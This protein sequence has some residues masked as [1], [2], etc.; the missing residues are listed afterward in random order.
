MNA[1]VLFFEELKKHIKPVKGQTDVNI[2]KLKR[3]SD[4]L[5]LLLPE[6]AF[7]LP[8][9]N[10]ARL[11]AIINEAGYTS[12]CLDLNIEVYN[13]SRN[14]EK[15][16]IVP[17]DPFNPHNLTKW[18]IDEYPKYLK[19]PVSKVLEKYIDKIV[20]LNPKVLGFTLYYCNEGPVDWFAS[21]LRKRLPNTIFICGGPNLHF[22]QHDIEK[23]KIFSLNNK[24]VFQ[25]GIVGE[26]ELI[27]LDILEEIDNGKMNH[28]GMKFLT[29]PLNQRININN[30][31][32]PNYSDMDFSKYDMPNGILTEFSRGCIAKCTFCSETHFWKYRQRNPLSALDEIEH[33]YKTKGTNVVWF[34]DSLINGNLK[35]LKEF[36]EGVIER[37]LKIKWA[38]FARCDERMDLEYLK[39]LNK[40]GCFIL[41]IGAESASNNVLSDMSKR[42]TRE[43]M[44]QNF[45]D[46]NKV[47][48]GVI[49]TWINGFPT[50]KEIDHKS[51]L[52]FLCRNREHIIGAASAA[53]FTIY[54]ENIVGQNP[55]RF[56]VANFTYDM[57]W[58]RDDFS[59]GK[60]HMLCRVKNYEILLQ[61][62]NDFSTIKLHPRP[63][64]KKLYNI[65]YDEPTLFNEIEYN[66]TNSKVLNTNL[67]IFGDSLIKQPFILFEILWKIRGGYEMNLKFDEK[68]DDL[69][70][71]L[72]VAS[73]YNAEYNF[74]INKKGD[75]SCTIVAKYTQPKDRP[76]KVMDFS[77]QKSS[78]IERARVFAKPT[79]GDGSRTK[80]ELI[81]L[82]KEEAYLNKTKDFSFDFKWE[83][84]GTWDTSKK[85]LF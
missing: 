69:E 83:G 54:A 72:P 25:Y 62:I 13:Q 52:T 48:I 81:E 45:S 21:E 76:F 26:A 29:Q 56:G 3:N 12:S 85:S 33:L 9:Y 46:F 8:P 17:F 73:P 71:G 65:K 34:L 58:I 15:D 5:F 35:S 79:W 30:F 7:D 61:E 22:R 18:E 23:G 42:M 20:E 53:G 84:S 37:G 67:N 39:L 32:I 19:E 55:E 70:F 4:I 40:S 60:P 11:S 31:P 6:W 50:E 14:W 38:G 36:A 27:I 77:Q 16:G 49:S 59:F 63:N 28:T 43:I 64:L 57:N 80:E 78:L 68:L 66:D 10:I 41:K 74:K 1:D 82:Y 24:P 75:W 44:E 51:T 47:G 2:T